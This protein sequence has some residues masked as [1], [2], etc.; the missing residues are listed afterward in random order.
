[1]AV[2]NIIVLNDLHQC[3][4]VLT[5]LNLSVIPKMDRYLK[6]SFALKKGLFKVL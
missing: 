4:K 2:I 1:M 3:K 5:K 6:H